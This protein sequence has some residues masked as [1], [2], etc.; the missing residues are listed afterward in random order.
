[1]SNW[2]DIFSEPGTL[3]A[4]V[5]SGLVGL[6]A[7][8]SQ[9]VVQRRHGGWHGFIGAVATG[10]TVSLIVGLSIQDAVTSEPLRLAI[11]GACTIVAE[12]IVS[13]LKAL[14]KGFAGDPF[15]FVIRVLDAWR[16]KPAMPNDK[17]GVTQ[18][19]PLEGEP[20]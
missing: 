6:V 19:S 5:S 4:I 11:V 7:S 17:T 3:G 20:K 18:P 14:A 1:M 16:G 15:G 12:D 9:G 8:I 2:K 13:G 10:V